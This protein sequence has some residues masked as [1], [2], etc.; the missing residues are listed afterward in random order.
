MNVNKSNIRKL[1]YLT[2]KPNKKKKKTKQKSLRHIHTKKCS[3]WYFFTSLNGHWW[4]LKQFWKIN[5]FLWTSSLY[6]TCSFGEH[7]GIDKMIRQNFQPY[8]FQYFWDCPDSRRDPLLASSARESFYLKGCSEK[9]QLLQ[10]S[11]ISPPLFKSS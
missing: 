11:V 2:I 7:F 3:V 5:N 8:G 6:C 9:C 1:L 10:R 4:Y